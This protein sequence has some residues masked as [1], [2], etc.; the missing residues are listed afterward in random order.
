MGKRIRKT[1]A[2]KGDRPLPRNKQVLQMLLTTVQRYIEERSGFNAR[3]RLRIQHMRSIQESPGSELPNQQV[4]D[5]LRD[6]AVK[7][8]GMGLADVTIA[9]PYF[10]NARRRQLSQRIAEDFAVWTALGKLKMSPAGVDQLERLLA[11]LDELLA[12]YRLFR[13]ELVGLLQN[14]RADVKTDLHAKI[15]ETFSSKREVIALMRKLDERQGEASQIQIATDFTHGD[16]AKA[17]TLLRYVRKFRAEMAQAEI[18]DPR[19]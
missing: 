5:D 16:K 4:M 19:G 13:D 14:R 8:A 11:T 9:E 17:A 12:E 7:Q 18:D 10:S 6:T 15:A 2:D 1:V 3:Q